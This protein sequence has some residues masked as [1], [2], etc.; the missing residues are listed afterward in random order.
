MEGEIINKIKETGFSMEQAKCSIFIA[1][2]DAAS[3]G[4]HI[5]NVYAREEYRHQS[6]NG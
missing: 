2:A 6:L 4:T 5:S 1:I 3:V